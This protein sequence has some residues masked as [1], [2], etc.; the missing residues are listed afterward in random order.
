[1]LRKAEVGR[2]KTELVVVDGFT[3]FTRTQHEMLQILARDAEQFFVSLPLEAEPCRA[4]L[5]AKP[6]VTLSILEKAMPGL[7]IEQLA[8]P[9]ETAWPAMARLEQTLFI[10]PR[11]RDKSTDAVGEVQGIEILAAAR[12]EGEVRLIGAKIKRLLVDGVAKP[13]EIAVVVRSLPDAG[14]LIGEVFGRMGIP[15]F[16]EL[17][18][19]LDRSPALRALVRLVQLDLN[20]WPFDEL[21]ALVRSNYFRPD[22][23]GWREG[24]TAAVVEQTIRRLQIP[25]GATGCWQRFAIRSAARRAQPQRA[26]KTTVLGDP[27]RRTSRPRRRTLCWSDWRARSIGCPRKRPWPTGPRRGSDWPRRRVCSVSWASPSATRRPQAP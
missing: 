14:A 8:R 13:S 25:M 15:V 19:T 3:D 6:L 21:L 16:L 24:K 26:A 17:G 1:M 12:Q 11:F 4:D 9:S 20:D 7:T 5:F 27:T 10:N 2:W 18:Q 22:W 23:P